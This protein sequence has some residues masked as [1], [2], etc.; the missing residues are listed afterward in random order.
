[1][2]LLFFFLLYQHISAK[3]KKDM[4]TEIQTHKTTVNPFC[5][6]SSIKTSI[7]QSKLEYQEYFAI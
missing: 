1:M 7:N 4:Q 3:E 6:F 5:Q 2:V